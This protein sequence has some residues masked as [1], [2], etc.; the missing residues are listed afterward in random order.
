MRIA[1]TAVAAAAA[2]AAELRVEARQVRRWEAALATTATR[3]PPATSPARTTSLEP[4]H[5]MGMQE[6]RLA[7]IEARALAR[8]Q[9]S[10][11]YRIQGQPP[12]CRRPTVIRAQR[13]AGPG[14]GLARPLATAGSSQPR[15]TTTDPGDDVSPAGT[16]SG[17]QSGGSNRLPARSP[18]FLPT[19]LRILDVIYDA[20]HTRPTDFPANLPST[21]GANK[22]V[23]QGIERRNSGARQQPGR[24]RHFG[25]PASKRRHADHVLERDLRDWWSACCRSHSFRPSPGYPRR[26][27]SHRC[28]SRWL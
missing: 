7:R 20:Y 27:A 24:L 5:R 25:E 8:M 23:I 26:R 13:R 6:A 16:T 3:K 2:L 1:P 9:A 4:K 17:T 15:V 28:S 18:A 12:R 14:N 19:R 10:P 22:V 21:D 11:M